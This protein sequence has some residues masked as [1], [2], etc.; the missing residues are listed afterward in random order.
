VQATPYTVP[1]G[2]MSFPA[3]TWVAAATA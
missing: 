1:D 2:N 3:R